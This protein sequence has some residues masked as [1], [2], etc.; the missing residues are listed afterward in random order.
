ML[1]YPKITVCNWT[2]QLRNMFY[3]TLLRVD[4]V[5]FW[6]ARPQPLLHYSAKSRQ[7]S[8]LACLTSHGGPTRYKDR[9]IS[10][11]VYQ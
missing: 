11:L 5:D 8:G 6:Q 2:G 4:M 7:G 3:S 1:K 10:K 9:L